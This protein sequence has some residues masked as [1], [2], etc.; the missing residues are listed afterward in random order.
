MK[1]GSAWQFVRARMVGLKENLNRA[2]PISPWSQSAES[3][4]RMG[5]WCRWRSEGH[6]IAPVLDGLSAFPQAG[7][8][9]RLNFDL[10]EHGL[11]P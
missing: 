1:F 10:P 5:E 9:I 4:R 11:S 2:F 3:I 8:G 7:K 6:R